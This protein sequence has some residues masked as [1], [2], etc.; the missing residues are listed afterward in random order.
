LEFSRFQKITCLLVTLLL[1]VASNARGS[2]IDDREILGLLGD[3]ETVVSTSRIPRP[4]SRVAEN[5][6]V[7]TAE[8]ITALNAHS[9]GEV[10]NTVPGIQLER[11]QTPG[12]FTSFS[13]QG[14]GESHVQLLID[15]VPQNNLLQGLA[16]SNLIPVQNIER[17]EIIKGAAS[18]SWGQ[19]LGGVINVITKMP[20]TERTLGG[21]VFTSLGERFTSDLRAEVSGSTDRLGYYLSGGQLHSDGLLPNNGINRGNAYGKLVY[22]LPNQG[23]VSFGLSLLQA[24]RGLDETELYHDGG[25]NLNGY[26]FLNLALPLTK[27]LSLEMQGYATE[28]DDETRFGH[29]DQGAVVVDNKFRLRES[30]RGVSSKLIWGDSSA[31]VVAGV[32]YEHG[33]T[34]QWD[35]L[36]PGSPFLTN[37]SGDRW[38]TYAN[39][40]YTLGALTILPGV[41]FDHTVFNNDTVSYTLGATYQ[42][43]EKN[44]LRSYVAK[45]YSLANAI[46][47]NGPQKVWTFQAGAESSSIPYLWLKGTFFYNDTWN[48]EVGDFDA[49][50]PG[51][52][53]RDQIKE[54]FEVEARTVPVY[55][56]FLS[57]GYTFIYARDSKTHTRLNDVPEHGIKLSL[58]Y[59]GSPTGLSGVVTGNYVRWNASEGEN[60]KYDGFVWDL[61]LTQKLFPGRELSPELFF[62]AHNIFDRAQYLNGN[63]YKNTGRWVEGGAR[64]KF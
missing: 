8:Q 3:G 40:S 29:F 47:N 45:G 61:S 42:L 12:N 25:S 13:F 43:S 59:T 1:A 28:G 60:A 38:S 37:R 27:K 63:Y 32:E 34:R 48:V 50:S 46:W 35:A 24:S 31:N 16:D 57:G 62:T 22:D 41:R 30:R 52:T 55:H 14:A 56:T 53:L 26:S 39:G 19:A 11:V 7:I 9:L 54:G 36:V 5:V 49:T 6:T 33:A 64:F 10:L 21:T 18:A 4:I 2:E 58:H 51:V 20:D 23:Q 17:I 44:V 15:G